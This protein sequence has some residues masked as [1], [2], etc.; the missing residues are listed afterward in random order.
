MDAPA[1]TVDVDKDQNLTTTTPSPRLT[2]APP[3]HSDDM[4]SYEDHEDLLKDLLDIQY[5]EL[6]YDY[7]TGVQKVAAALGSATM[8]RD[9]LIIRG[10]YVYLREEIERIQSHGRQAVAIVGQPGIGK[11]VFLL[12]I[13]FYRLERKLPTAIQFRHN[14]CFIFDEQGVTA[15]STDDVPSDRL[16]RCW[17]LSD[18]NAI[19]HQPCADFQAY[20]ALVVQA[21]SP[22]PDRWKE[23]L[24][25][26]DGVTVAMELPTVLEIGAIIKEL[27]GNTSSTYAYVAKWGPS[28]RTIVGIVLSGNPSAAEEVE[29][30]KA[31]TAAVSI[32]RAYSHYTIAE[33]SSLV[34][35]RPCHKEGRRLYSL[36][37]FIP[38]N[39]LANILESHRK[40]LKNADSLNLFALLSCHAYTRQAAGWTHE[41]RMHSRLLAGTEDAGRLQI[42]N[43][44]DG[45]SDYWLLPSAKLLPGT[46]AALTTVGGSQ[47]FYWMPL[48]SNFPGIDAVLGDA[49]GRIFA[50]QA[51]IAKSHCSPLEGLRRL[52]SKLRPAVRTSC[53][54]HVVV[55]ADEHEI[56]DKLVQQF[57]P[58]LLTGWKEGLGSVSVWS[59]VL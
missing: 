30:D 29:L 39:H 32:C 48:A 27:G 23:W 1:A 44:A 33:G 12:A 49:T 15:H 36:H 25:Q 57:S 50:L 16:S 3:D 19:V 58:E 43:S 53:S 10:D 17:A 31:N 41:Q 35:Q 14:Y 59:C 51:T 11:T 37:P 34:F 56:A 6:T 46:L 45:G 20:A 4:A 13:L 55:V 24:R 52:W 40:R 18:S 2:D 7:L 5:D 21:S 54:L 9:C 38:T 26:K 28:I 22:G 47:S 8:L 42:F